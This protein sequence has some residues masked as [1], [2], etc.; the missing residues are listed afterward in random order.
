[1]I[2]KQLQTPKHRNIF[3]RIYKRMYKA[4]FHARFQIIYSFLMFI[5]ISVYKGLLHL[6]NQ[7][8]KM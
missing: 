2:K 7:S 1:M 6:F 4:T 3:N 8:E 5:A